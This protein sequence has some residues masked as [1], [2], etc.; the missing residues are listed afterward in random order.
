MLC[1]LFFASGA[2]GLVYQQLWLRQL[3]LVFGVTVYAV[4]TVLAAFFGGL[5][6]G[7]FLAGRLVGRTSRPLLWYGV[8]EIVVGALAVVTARGARR[9]RGL[10]VRSPVSSPDSVAVLTAVRF[11]LSFAVLIVPATLLGAT[12]P[13][14]ASS[15]A[16]RGSQVGE[17][18]GLLYASEHRR[19]H[20]R[21]AAGRVLDDR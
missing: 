1:L 15:S 20:R 9:R 17:R 4:A 3:S 16:V 6:L 8:A 2:C 12:L 14:V 18:V 13:L 19:R 11:V 7:S 5:A 10:Y 21:H